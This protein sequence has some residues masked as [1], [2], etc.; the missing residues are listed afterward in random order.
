MGLEGLDG[1]GN[2]RRERRV[3]WAWGQFELGGGLVN[4]DFA[5]GGARMQLF[6][7]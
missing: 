3:Y 5:F 4:L 2:G 6:L 1:V 7:S